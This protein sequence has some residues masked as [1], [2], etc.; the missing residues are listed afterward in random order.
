MADGKTE[1]RTEITADPSQ[2]EA[3]MRRLVSSTTGAAEQMKSKLGNVAE[4]FEKVTKQLNILA[5]VV[6][7]GAFFK[8]AIS[9]ANKLNGEAMNLS[10]SLGLTGDEAATLRTALG[11][12]YTDTDTYVGAFQ[13]FAG[14]LRKNEEGIKAMGVQTRDSSGN[15]RDS[16]T[17]FRE[18][19]ATVGEF[20]PGL[21]QTTAAMELFGKSV[22]DVRKLQKLNNDVL[23]DAAEKNK[24]LGMTVT[25]EGVAAT[26]AYKA[27]MNDVGDVL[28]A[29][30]NTV[31]KAVMP[32]FTE[33]AQYFASTGPYVLNVFKVA[34][35]P[36]VLAFDLLKATVQTAAGVIFEAFSTLLDGSKI[37]SDV[38]VKIFQGDFSGAL[39]SAA[40]L[41]Q[42]FNQAFVNAFRNSVGVGSDMWQ[43]MK[44]NMGSLWGEGTAI[45]APK[46][47]TRTMGEFKEKA[48][49]KDPGRVP[50]WEADLAA[51]KAA[52][53]RQGLLEDQYREMS[54]ADELAYWREMAARRDLTENEKIAVTRKSAE[55]E[56]AL[57]KEG[58]EVRVATLQA[59]AAQYKSNTDERL[60]IER[61]IQARY[62][63]GTKEY[64]ASQKRIV[65]IQRQA[66]EQQTQITQMRLQAERDAR[67]QTIA[68]EEQTVQTAAELGIVQQEE[69][70]ARQAD[71]EV[72]RQAIAMQA[73]QER[74]RLAELDP[75]RNPVEIERIHREMEQLEQQH[76]LRMGQ[77]RGAQAVEQTRD[78]RSGI[79]SLQS[80]W[81]GLLQ[82]L[83]MGSITIGG[84]IRGVFM[85]VG[86]AVI[87]T[88][89]NMAAQWA[90][91]MLLQKVM[92]KLTAISQITANAG[93][94]GSAAVASAAAI[95]GYGWAIAPAAGAEA[96]AAA[97]SYLPA[98]S[99][100]G[101]YDIPGTINPIVQAHA[102]EMIL[103]AKHADVIRDLA[104]QRDAAGSM[105]QQ[106]AQQ[107]PVVLR[108]A[109][110]GQFFIAYKADLA[111]ALN[112]IDR[113][114]ARTSR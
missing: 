52:L 82:Q 97:M 70:L 93:I 91:N 65:E 81:A 71:F 73:L 99:A 108:G 39:Q 111:K 104:D 64:E 57:I 48:D 80:S 45:D 114:N 62:Q 31:G 63:Q 72:R 78:I 85:A 49:K 40:A 53:Q 42:R 28:D 58:F 74:L 2:Y 56:M 83:A 27:A 26:K 95:P 47:G 18:A 107:R 10:K 23:D 86:Q 46:G 35:T 68:L 9:T 43:S 96:F 41:G 113:D 112:I 98:A 3:A 32:A 24:Q 51:R 89:S 106:Q 5:G 7:G 79:Q 55:V 75:D 54:K 19:L 77:I 30:M 12:I 25:K 69:V 50:Q 37:I 101:G 29:V 38:F 13:K 16:N 87:S 21:D 14:Q 102:K 84:F 103:P 109:T 11:D 61:E 66:A 90:V 92:G 34:L 1:Y 22:D 17:L 4:H 76:Q 20:K 8:E 15:L 36:V 59:E 67:L 94:A 6:A 110:A 88:L 33:L 44:K 100:A 60:R 105:A